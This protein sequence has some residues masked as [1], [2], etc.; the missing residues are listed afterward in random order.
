M[1]ISRL[2]AAIFLTL[3]S[4]IT[5]DSGTSR[6]SRKKKCP[7]CAVTL[8]NHTFGDQATDCEGPPQQQKQQ[9]QQTPPFSKQ[10]SA[11]ILKAT[12]T[13]ADAKVDFKREQLRQLE[14]EQ[15]R[16]MR[17]ISSEEKKLD[18]EIERRKNAIEHL[19]SVRKSTSSTH[20]HLQE[21]SFPPPQ[22][23][24][25]SIAAHSAAI[26]DSSTAPL[27]PPKNVST[28]LGNISSLLGS[29]NIEGQGHPSQPHQ[30][31]QSVNPLFSSSYPATSASSY[32]PVDQS[33][34]FLRP[35]RANDVTRGKALR[36]VDFVSRIRPSEDE[37]ILSY[38]SN[39]KLT[40]TLQD[41]K[42]KLS[43]VTVEQFNIANLRI[44][45]ELLFS[46]KL[47]TLRDIQEYLSYVIKIL[48]LANKYTWESVLLY[49]DEFRILQHTYGFSWA[50]DHSH[51]HEA[52]LMPRWAAH[53]SRNK[54]GSP[55]YLL[56]YNNS[57]SGYK[58]PSNFVTHLS[59]GSEICRLFNC[60][61][62]CQ[63]PQCKF[64][65]VC[66]RKVGSQA[67]GKN[68]A[69][70]SHPPDSQDQ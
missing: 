68:H 27:L 41:R 58:H 70:V 56:P 30:Q 31:Q 44:F 35:T 7:G 32:N 3:V 4:P 38:D 29:N 21:E 60:R 28:L 40:L 67:C 46:G 45:Y 12:T 23:R 50:T 69:G 20:P 64:S 2:I 15:Q 24:D 63:R 61:K 34:L 49:D 57:D 10:S 48:E 18:E 25:Q 54:Q 33:E 5:G 26:L 36:I 59:S 66:N 11:T 6:G 53:L 65:H 1:T 17:E 13:P 8:E 22:P 55:S 37:K 19:K 47:S 42:P 43:S 9:P 14:L 51:L 39:C 62:G 16:L 52:V